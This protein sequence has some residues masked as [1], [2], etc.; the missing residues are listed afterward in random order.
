MSL[1]W[2]ATTTLLGS[3]TSRSSSTACA[4]DHTIAQ[5]EAGKDE[6]TELDKAEVVHFLQHHLH[7]GLKSE[8]M[9]EDDPLVLWQS[10]KDRFNQ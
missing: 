5:P 9:N 3:L 10:L 2:T 1:P 8:Y 6:R 7:L 4:S